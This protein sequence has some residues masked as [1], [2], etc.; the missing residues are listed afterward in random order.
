MTGNSNPNDLDTV[1]GIEIGAAT[2]E[3]GRKVSQKIKTR[4]IIWPSNS[5][6]GYLSE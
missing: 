4:V 2:T 6:S 5:S 3:N 1:V